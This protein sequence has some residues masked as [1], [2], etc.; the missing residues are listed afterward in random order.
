M[1]LCQHENVALRFP[2]AGDRLGTHHVLCWHSNTTLLYAVPA[3]DWY[4]GV[5]GWAHS[6]DMIGSS[7]V[8][9]L[10]SHCGLQSSTQTSPSPSPHKGQP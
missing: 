4:G 6:W 9:Q 8:R 7:E 10:E 1:T 2:A 5:P 3:K